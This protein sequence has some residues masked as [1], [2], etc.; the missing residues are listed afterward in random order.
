MRSREAEVP[1]T[2]A[3]AASLIAKAGAE[4]LEVGTFPAF[5]ATFVAEGQVL[6][7]GAFSEVTLYRE[8]STGRAVAVKQIKVHKML[9]CRALREAVILSQ[10]AHPYIVGFVGCYVR[11]EGD[12]LLLVLEICHGV[13]LFELVVQ[14]LNEDEC[15]LFVAQ[16][17]TALAY[18]H[19]HGIIH[20]DVKPENVRVEDRSHAVLLD[21]GL[22]KKI[23]DADDAT[24]PTT[25]VGTPCYLAP[26]IED[27]YK[28]R[29]KSYSVEVDCWSLGALLY[30]M[31]CAR[32]P[33]FERPSMTVKVNGLPVSR[34]AK[35]LVTRLMARDPHL[36]IPAAAVPHHPWLALCSPLLNED[37]RDLTTLHRWLEDLALVFPSRLS[38]DALAASGDNL[39]VQ[40]NILNQKLDHLEAL[41]DRHDKQASIA[42]F[43]EKRLDLKRHWLAVLATLR[44]T[45]ATIPRLHCADISPCSHLQAGVGGAT[46]DDV[47]HRADP[48]LE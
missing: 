6:G 42:E 35:D 45:H 3:P 46:F 37:F 48:D 40:V 15:Q 39:Q 12:S 32:F 1:L 16:L 29:R 18:L 8:R 31:L 9:G 27:V 2:A 28:G 13:E 5:D 43:H 21:F 47:R 41:Q 17:A 22:S 38:K 11:D 24:Y 7:R 10:V 44:R 19:S 26:E 14:G 30:V 25:F 34:L 33:E 23:D 36:R 4:G 20:R